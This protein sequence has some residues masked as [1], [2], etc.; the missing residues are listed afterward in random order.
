MSCQMCL[1]FLDR[2]FLLLCDFLG[3]PH[4]CPLSEQ[5]LACLAPFEVAGGGAVCISGLLGLVG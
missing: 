3:L 4:L 5:L 1:I 2:P